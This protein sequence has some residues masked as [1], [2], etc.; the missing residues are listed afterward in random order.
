MENGS[1]EVCSVL[2]VN[3]VSTL[4]CE[5]CIIEK[6]HIIGYYNRPTAYAL[7]SWLYDFSLF[8]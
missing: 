1:V 4:Y 7:P 6:M 5:H 3:T 2:V 8:N